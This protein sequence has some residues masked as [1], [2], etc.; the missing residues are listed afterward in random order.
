MQNR[1]L[2]KVVIQSLDPKTFFC[3]CLIK[4][5]AITF[6]YRITATFCEGL[7][8]KTKEKHVLIAEGSK[9]CLHLE[10]NKS[11][12]DARCRGRTKDL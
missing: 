3:E 9:H 8:P 12:Q 6:Y 11:D 2:G 4:S 1:Y 10:I 5:W 7:A